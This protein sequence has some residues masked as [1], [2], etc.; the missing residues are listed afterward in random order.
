MHRAIRDFEYAVIG[1]DGITRYLRLNCVP[2]F[3]A[4]GKFGGYSGT[5]TDVTERKR[6]EMALMKSEQS[7]RV[8]ILELEDTR[9]AQ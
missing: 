2:V 9:L 1:D 8:Q 6:T 7:Q 4:A 5:D 3:D